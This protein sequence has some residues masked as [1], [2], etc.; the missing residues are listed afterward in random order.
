MEIPVK[1]GILG[2]TFSCI[3]GTQ[4]RRLRQGDRF[5][6][7]TPDR[8]IGFSNSQLEE[9]RKASLARVICDNNADIT[10]L[11]PRVMRRP[12]KF[13]NKIDFCDSLPFIDL[14]KWRP[15]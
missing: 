7:E 9:L 14:S 6:Y 2:P 12:D 3:L 15:L 4:F 13:Q 11:Q 8:S 1:N 10:R 5:W